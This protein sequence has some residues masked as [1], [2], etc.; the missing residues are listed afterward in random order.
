M[1]KLLS[2]RTFHILMSVGEW[3][4][5]RPA[6]AEAFSGP[7]AQPRDLHEDVCWLWL[8]DAYES[9]RH[10]CEQ[11]YNTAPEC[12]FHVRSRKFFS[13]FVIAVFFLQNFITVH[14][15]IA[16]VQHW[17]TDSSVGFYITKIRDSYFPW[18]TPDPWLTCDHFVGKASAMGQLT[19]PTQPSTLLGSVNEY[20]S[21]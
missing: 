8:A 5:A 19:R 14:N 11:Y 3:T 6:Q 16:T 17:N 21:M 13:Y 7:S 20:W 9:A 18:S 1:L 2:L 10:L 15:I 4:V 12:E